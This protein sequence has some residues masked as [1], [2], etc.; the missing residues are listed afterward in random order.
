[1]KDAVSI[2]KETVKWDVF[3]GFTVGNAAGRLSFGLTND[4]LS[5]YKIL[6]LTKSFYIVICCALYMV[7]FFIMGTI[8]NLHKSPTKVNAL[9]VLVGVAYGGIFTMV[10]AYMKEVCAPKK[11]GFLLGVALV[12]L[13]AVTYFGQ[14]YMFKPLFLS[15]DNAFRDIGEG[16][17]LYTPGLDGT[18]KPKYLGQNTL[19][20]FCK[21]AFCG[22]AIALVVSI[23]VWIQHMQIKKAE[24][25]A[26]EEAEFTDVSDDE[27]DADIVARK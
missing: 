8:E 23:F 24:L 16:V 2:F 11:T 17:T 6:A 25:A 15:G 12:I 21:I 19:K 20:D 10:T 14:N 22:N 7:L 9:V 18:A 4:F 13:A 27:N 1:L 26:E 3:V 5:G